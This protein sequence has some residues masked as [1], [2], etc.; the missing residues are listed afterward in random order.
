M[1]RTSAGGVQS[2]EIQ[3]S[4]YTYAADAEAS[5]SYAITLDPAPSAYTAGQMF[6]FKANTA[7]TGA[8]SLNV[9]GLGAQTIKKRTG[10]DLA[11]NDIQSGSI[12]T[13][14]YDGTNFQMISMLANAPA[15]S[16]DMAASTY[17][18]AAITEQLVGLTAVQTLTN[19]TLTSPTLTAPAIGTPASGVLTNCTGLP[20]TTGVTG[21]LP[22]SNIAQI[23]TS[24]ILGRSTAGT[25]DIE[26]LTA[27]S[28]RTVLGL[29]TSDSP[30]FTAVNVGH[31]TD[32]TITRVSA[33]KI[34]VEGVNVVTVSS[35]DTLTNKT[36]TSPTLTTPNIGTPS[37]GVLTNCTG[38]PVS[39]ITAS[40]STALGVGSVELGNATDTT[41][42]RASAGVVAV[43]GV[44]VPTISSTN[45]LTNKRITKRR[46][47]T[48]SSAT[49]TINTDD[50]D[51]YSLTAQ[52]ADIT[53]FTTNLSG[54]PSHGD[55]LIIEI[56]GTA[57]RAITWG[58]SFEASTVAL[59]TTTVTTNM[60]TVGFFY[61]S[62]TSKWRC[63]ASA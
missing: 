60:L 27:T 8:A 9:N 5:D 40:T 46:G 2:S 15:G 10:T 33:G 26:S 17:D 24:R 41:I 50:Y 16:G 28:A 4:V 25:G 48:T 51:I 39:G 42:S 38:L 36:L 22:F 32:T 58:A 37:A 35:T 7:N 62:A 43:E 20:L 56:T 49:P 3:D 31:A 63:V 55:S 47:S 13:V 61:N 54:T 11:N 53:S 57:A 14:V 34:A 18:P 21:D 52:A 19:K 12:V 59:P 23:A 44:A 30:Q 45:T 6:I 1:A 29:A